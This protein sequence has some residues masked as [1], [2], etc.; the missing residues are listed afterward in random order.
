[1][2]LRVIFWVAF[3]TTTICQLAAYSLVIAGSVMLI[4]QSHNER[5]LQY[6]HKT[7]AGRHDTIDELIT[8]WNQHPF[9][10]VAVTSDSV[11]PD[12]TEDFMYEF[13]PGTAGGCECL[14]N[15][16]ETDHQVYFNDLWHCSDVEVEVDEAY[17]PSG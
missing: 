16:T 8:S 4:D 10:D 12:G 11:C 9:V 15:A 5:W 17:D 2:R 14:G 13:W 6:Y 1:M 3:V 7:M